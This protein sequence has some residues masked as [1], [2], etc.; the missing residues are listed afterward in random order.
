LCWPVLQ[1]GIQGKDLVCGLVG[2]LAVLIGYVR[3]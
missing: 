3:R 2:S 1:V